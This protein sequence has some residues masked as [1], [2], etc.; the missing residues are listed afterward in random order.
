MF[1]MDSDRADRVGHRLAEIVHVD[2]DR[3]PGAPFADRL[4]DRQ[5]V[6]PLAPSR[7]SKPSTLGGAHS[8][9]RHRPVGGLAEPR[10]APSGHRAETERAIRIQLDVPGPIVDGS[11]RAGVI[12]GS[13]NAG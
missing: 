12:E 5:A 1:A 9:T 2:P 3:D 11:Q 6:T 4:D 7:M 8:V 10:V 13:K